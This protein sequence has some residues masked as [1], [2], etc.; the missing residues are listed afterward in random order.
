M[1]Q[2]NITRSPG[3]S[4]CVDGEP[5]VW[6]VWKQRGKKVRFRCVNG[7]ASVTPWEKQEGTYDMDDVDPSE[8]NVPDTV[9]IAAKTDNFRVY[10]KSCRVDALR[11][12]LIDRNITGG[13]KMRKADIIDAIMAHDFEKA[14]A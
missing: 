4:K 12:M 6:E 3:D 5:H 7:C 11:D 8:K 9:D 1:T 14:N 13:S 2:H 10:L